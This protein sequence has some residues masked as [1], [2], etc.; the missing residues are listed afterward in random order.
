MRAMIAMLAAGLV[1]AGCGSK[2]KDDG[3]TGDGGGTTVAAQGGDLDPCSFLSAAEMTAITTDAVTNLER[4][5]GTA[6]IYHSKPDVD[7]DVTVHATG[8]AEQMATAHRVAGLLGGM[9]SAVADKG[10]AG[11]D[12]AALLKPDATAVPKI[13]DEAMWGMNATLSVR[14]GDA[15]VEVTPPLMHDPANHAGYPLV[16]NA[17][18]RAI[19]VKVATAVLAKLPG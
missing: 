12:A 17:E 13:G 19:A 2:A 18:K 5:E 1:L 4:R 11:A 8:G 16:P 9:G 6:C 15:F 10:G 14:K 7:T 3:G